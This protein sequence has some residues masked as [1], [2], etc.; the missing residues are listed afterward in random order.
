MRVNSSHYQVWGREGNRAFSGRVKNLAKFLSLTFGSKSGCGD[1]RIH[2]GLR[3]GPV[4][5]ATGLQ[6]L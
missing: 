4:P 5:E 3:R 2:P 1:P 6:L